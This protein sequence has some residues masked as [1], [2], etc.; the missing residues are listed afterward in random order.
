M[1]TLYDIFI[2]RL[3]EQL[4]ENRCWCWQGSLGPSGYGRV[5]HNKREYMAHRIAWEIYNAE[6]IP[7]ELIVRHTCDNPL[8][9]N[10]LHLILGTFLDNAKDRNLRN[11]TAKGVK[12]N[13]SKLSDNDV[14]QIRIDHS[15]GVLQKDLAQKYN[16]TDVN[17]SHIVC[18]KTWKHVGGPTVKP[19]TRLSKAQVAYIREALASGK[20]TGK[21][22]AQQFN[23]S[24][25][26]ISL[27]KNNI[28]HRTD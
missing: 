28:N 8:C 15:N 5:C 26:A 23:C 13:T 7:P 21:E 11:R 20:L 3:P 14:M 27:I 19:Q 18:G 6:P 2:K 4:D 17:I 9:V 25:S 12:I 1:L 24:E 10:P 16:V 22:L